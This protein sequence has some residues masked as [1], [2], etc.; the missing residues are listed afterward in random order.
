MHYIDVEYV[1]I[2]T[3]TYSVAQA[4]RKKVKYIL[5]HYRQQLIVCLSF[6][7]CSL[8]HIFGLISE[9]MQ[10]AIYYLMLLACKK[11]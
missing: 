9:D 7:S 11:M 8:W 10:D 2:K 1:V 3:S 6:A 5:H 4:M